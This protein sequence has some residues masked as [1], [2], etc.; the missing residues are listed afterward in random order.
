[1]ELVPNN[2]ILAFFFP[3]IYRRARR[4][5]SCPLIH[6]KPF[7]MSKDLGARRKSET[8]VNVRRN[9]QSF[10]EDLAFDILSSIL[11]TAVK[12]VL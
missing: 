3:V 6:E 11:P 8:I 1:M 10:A 2:L 4:W 9:L 12:R 5:G 7:L